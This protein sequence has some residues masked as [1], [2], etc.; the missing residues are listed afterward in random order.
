MFGLGKA[1]SLRDVP[2]LPGMFE[3][4]IRIDVARSI[5]STDQL[6]FRPSASDRSFPVF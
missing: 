5:S 1:H 3:T 6:E 2:Q 4:A